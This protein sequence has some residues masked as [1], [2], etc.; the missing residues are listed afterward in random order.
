MLWVNV[1]DGGA[2]TRVGELE[3]QLHAHS[4]THTITTAHHAGL[5]EG[6]LEGWQG[7]RK[8]THTAH[9]RRRRVP[10]SNRVAEVS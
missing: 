3:N 5:P 2:L 9:D 1:G 4:A 7:R 10:S 8:G 6:H